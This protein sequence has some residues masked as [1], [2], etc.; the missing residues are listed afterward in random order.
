MRKEGK[1]KVYDVPMT[2]VLYIIHCILIKKEE[3]TTNKTKQLKM[4][5]VW[6]TRYFLSEHPNTALLSRKRESN[7]TLHRIPRKQ[8][9][10]VAKMFGFLP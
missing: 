9:S 6:L 3:P 4:K 8:Y 2:Y 7:S 10:K 1:C 5:L